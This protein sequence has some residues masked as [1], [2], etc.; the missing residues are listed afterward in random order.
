MRARTHKYVYGVYVYTELTLYLLFF[1]FYFMELFKLLDSSSILHTSSV[2][3]SEKIKDDID[4]FME[5]LREDEL[6]LVKFPPASL[7]PFAS[8]ISSDINHLLRLL[9]SPHFSFSG[10]SFML[11]SLCFYSLFPALF[12]VRSRVIWFSLASWVE[13]EEGLD[14][15]KIIHM[16][17]RIWDEPATFKLEELSAFS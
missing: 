4:G 5:V 9:F 10:V 13:E 1:L 6:W 12:Q 15:L 16:L 11:L 17:C 3:K 7:L 8:L 2:K 14:F